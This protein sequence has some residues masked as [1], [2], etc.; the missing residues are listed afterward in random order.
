LREDA[1]KLKEENTKL[2]GMVES[3]NELNTEIA[4]EIGLDR[5]GEDVEDEGEDEDGDDGG[6]AAA[7]PVV[8][9]PPYW[10]FFCSSTSAHNCQCSTSPG[11]FS[12]YRIYIFPRKEGSLSCLR[13]TQRVNA[14]S[15]TRLYIGY[16]NWG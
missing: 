1:Q 15:T 16:V 7:P 13:L 3:H 4:K 12:R 6:D 2:E 11:V 14:M 5:M 8:V 9:A 10:C